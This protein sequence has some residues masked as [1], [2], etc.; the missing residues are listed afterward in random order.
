MSG[1][2][3]FSV[4]QRKAG[5][6]RPMP[7]I[8]APTAAKILRTGLM[9]AGEDVAGLA[10]VANIP[11]E[12]RVTLEAV[13][14]DLDENALLAMV[15]GPEGAYGLVVLDPQAMAALI[16][17]Q[18]TGQV[19]TRAVPPRRPTRTDAI[20]CADFID[21]VLELVDSRAREAELDLAPALSGFRYVLA[22]AEARAVSMTLADIAYRR[23]TV[24][25]D[26]ARGAK[27]GR[28]DIIL[29]HEPHDQRA[30]GQP[31]QDPHVFTEALGTLVQGARAE[32]NG[33]LHQVDMTISEVAGL[34]VGSVIPI[35]RAALDRVIVA[36]INGNPVSHGRLGMQNGHRAIRVDMAATAPPSAPGAARLDAPPSAPGG[37]PGGAPGKMPSG[38]IAADP[39]AGGKPDLAAQ[40]G[41]GDTVGEMTDGDLAD[42]GDFA[43]PGRLGDPGG[44]PPVDLGDL[45]DLASLGSD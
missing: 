5:S 25:L 30:P 31:G 18:T 1:D 44:A 32:L 26:L 14:E 11:Q 6:G 10:I 36:D 35:P 37:G 7:E 8:G 43:V 24:G 16:E 12:S 4:M 20:M 2:D 45:P 22:L 33:T 28:I 3:S 23:F 17:I 40:T 21:R 38:T 41:I 13:V 29:P 19:A 9:Q 39:G 42:L 27:Q 15:E 34:T